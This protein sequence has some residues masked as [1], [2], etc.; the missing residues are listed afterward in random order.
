M[1]MDRDIAQAVATLSYASGEQGEETFEES[2]DFGP[3]TDEWD[4]G[5]DDEKP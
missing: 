5:D 3:P 2:M 1:V 4:D